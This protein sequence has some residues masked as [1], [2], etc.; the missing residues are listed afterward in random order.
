MK[1]RGKK[2]NSVKRYIAIALIGILFFIIGLGLLEYF[3][4]VFAA[5]IFAP[6]FSPVYRWFRKRAKHDGGAALLTVMLMVLVVI[7]PIALFGALL[8]TE[9]ASMYDE[10]GDALQQDISAAKFSFDVQSI[11]KETI[12]YMVSGLG[13][14][15]SN[16]LSGVAEVSIRLFIMFFIIYYL[17]IN[18]KKWEAVLRNWLPFNKEHN[19]QLIKNFKRSSRGFIMGQGLTA[20]IQG[21]VGGV[22]FLIFGLDGA[23]FF[24]FLMAVLSLLPL[25]GTALVWLP[26]GIIQVVIGNHYGG[27]GILIWGFVIVSNI[28]NFVRPAIMKNMI[29]VHPLVTVL[30]IFSGLVVFG[31]VGLIIGPLL[32][33]LAIDSAKMFRSEWYG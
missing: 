30:G 6:I 13:T 28:D 16:I 1:G 24:G 11:G 29:G 14:S 23:L 10:Y 15:L 3:E 33:S 9:T 18:G 20:I 21:I 22:G 31:L 7:V 32:L 5:F 27:F 19:L 26:I 2:K 12:K 4:A 25:I 17:L 8:F